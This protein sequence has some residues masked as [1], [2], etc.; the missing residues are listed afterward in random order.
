MFGIFCNFLETQNWGV[1]ELKHTYYQKTKQNHENS[2]SQW[3]S[4]SDAN[5]SDKKI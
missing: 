3:K 1:N 2:F 4:K 5:N